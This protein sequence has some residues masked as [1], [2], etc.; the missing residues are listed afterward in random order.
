MRKRNCRGSAP[1]PKRRSVYLKIYP[2]SSSLCSCNL[3]SVLCYAYAT[4]LQ[5]LIWILPLAVACRV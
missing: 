4:A 3:E 5:K 2:V 1:S